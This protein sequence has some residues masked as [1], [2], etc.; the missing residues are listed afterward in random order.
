MDNYA[1]KELD[2]INKNIDLP[3][4]LVTSRSSSPYSNLNPRLE[5][6]F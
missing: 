4:V 1:Q 5:I 2:L 3:P 6:M